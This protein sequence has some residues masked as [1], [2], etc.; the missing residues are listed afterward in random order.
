MLNICTLI[1]KIVYDGISVGPIHKNLLKACNVIIE[2]WRKIIILSLKTEET[3]KCQISNTIKN[4]IQKYEG[5]LFVSRYSIDRNTDLERFFNVDAVSGII[6]TAK[7]LDREANS[8]HNLTI[9][10]IESRRL[11]T[12]YKTRQV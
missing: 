6:S 4:D 11:L 5:C 10:A 7:P 12:D 9:F 3:L 2:G 8:V 1:E